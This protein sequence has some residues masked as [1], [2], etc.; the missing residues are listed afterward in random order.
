MKIEKIMIKSNQ[1]ENVEGLTVEYPYVMHFSDM[2][3]LKAPWHW[4]EEVEFDYVIS[5]AL[6]VVTVNGKYIFHKDEAFFM[7]SNV[8]ACMHR[9]SDAD[10]TVIHSHLFNPIFLS[11]HYK[12]IFETK[13]INPVLQN[14]KLDI[15]EIRGTDENQIRMLKAL[16]QV[17]YIQKEAD[18]EFETRSLFSEIWKLLLREMEQLPKETHEVDLQ[19]QDRMQSMMS[20]IQQNYMEKISLEE[21]ASAA[22]ISTR[23]CL[24]CFRSSIDRSPIEYLM[25]YRLEMAKKMLRETDWLVTDIGLQTGFS[26]N[27]YFGKVFKEKCGETPA[28]YRK[29]KENKKHLTST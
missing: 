8:M 5:G 22:S 14:K 20:Y 16:R 1:E 12:S 17:A 27:A 6:E 28:E 26:S 13:Y 29:K 24:R 21:I 19:N 18:M 2:T 23:E 3:N 9:A 15:L 10:F 4:H 7:N 25:E 11:G